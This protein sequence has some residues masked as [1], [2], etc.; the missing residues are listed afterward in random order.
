M[1][2]VWLPAEEREFSLHCFVQVGS[3]AHASFCPK[4]TGYFFP[5]VE[6]SEV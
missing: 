4:G 3:E 5:L 1:A 2:W 6:P